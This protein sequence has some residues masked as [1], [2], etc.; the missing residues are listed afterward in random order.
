MGRFETTAAA[1]AARREPYPPAFFAAVAEK[2]GLTG[3]EA[4]IDLGI[5]YEDVMASLK[6]LAALVE[7]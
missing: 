2:L 4:L 1:Y 7:G 6:R 5:G 3:R